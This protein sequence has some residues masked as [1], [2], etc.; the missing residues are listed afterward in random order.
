MMM[1]TTMPTTMQTINAY[2]EA[3]NNTDDDVRDDS[4]A[5][6]K[7]DA[8]DANDGANDD[9]DDDGNDDANNTGNIATAE[10]EIIEENDADSYVSKNGDDDANEDGNDDAVDNTNDSANKDTDDDATP[11]KLKD[12]VSDNGDGDESSKKVTTHQ[13]AKREKDTERK[14]DGKDGGAD[15]RT[16]GEAVQSETGDSIIEG[17]QQNKDKEKK[18]KKNKID[19]RGGNV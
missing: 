19:R 10:E 5:E 11:G 17:N 4:D 13:G 15:K 7:N 6:A 9:A 12:D 16:K 18:G 1:L 8:D 3:K 2:D 14:K